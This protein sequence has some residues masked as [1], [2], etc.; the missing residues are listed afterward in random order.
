MKLKDKLFYAWCFILFIL[1]LLLWLN[2]FPKIHLDKYT[3][4]FMFTLMG[5]SL[6]PF[7]EKIKIGNFLEIERLKEKIEEVKL[8]QYLG[9]VIKTS[10]GDLFYYDSDGKHN[11]PDKETAIFLRTSK[12]ELLINKDEL[13]RMKTSFPIESVLSSRKVDWHGH[14]FVILNGKKYHVDS[15]SFLADLGIFAVSDKIG[16]E[17]I[18]LL[19]TGR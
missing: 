4:I 14:I 8:T 15:W 16:D 11:L 9:E 3:L 1:V 10:N 5:I 13:E 2:V 6:L 12:G 18:R 17:E 19:P 7:M